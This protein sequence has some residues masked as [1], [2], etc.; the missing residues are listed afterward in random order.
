M[1]LQPL[2]SVRSVV[3][4]VC[5]SLLVLASL[6]FS[7]DGLEAGSPG[8]GGFYD[9]PDPLPAG[10]PGMVIRAEP[11]PVAPAGV[12]GWR[13]LYRSTRPDGSAR[14][15][16][17]VIFA[18]DE[19]AQAG[20][21]PVVAWAHPTTGIARR[22]APS[23]L[24]PLLPSRIAGLTDLLARGYVVTATDYP[25]LGTPSPHPYLI[26]ESEGRAVL[27]SVRAAAQLPEAGAGRTY[28]L[29]GHS[30]GGHAVLFA[31]QLAASYAPELRLVGIA[32]AAPPT[33]L[34]TLFALNV[35]SIVGRLL[36]AFAFVSWSEVY[37]DADYRHLVHAE[38]VPLIEAIA[39]TCVRT[40]PGLLAAVLPAWQLGPDFLRRQPQDVEP[41]RTLFAVNSPGA[42]PLGAPALIVQGTDDDIV[43]PWVTEAYVA[44]RCRGG[45]LVTLWLV[46]GLDHALAGQVSAPGVAAWLADRFAGLPVP[47]TCIVQQ[48]SLQTTARLEVAVLVHG[49]LPSRRRFGHSGKRAADTRVPERGHQ[50]G[51]ERPTALGDRCTID[52]AWAVH[53]H[54]GC[55]ALHLGTHDR[56][57][58]RLRHGVPPWQRH[59][60]TDVF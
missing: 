23:L 3:T 30:Q 17:G 7:V 15:V 6:V 60:P 24:A 18:P 53:A 19:P 56:I 34:A 20:G 52:R 10:P 46:P 50:E 26:G 39:R 29:W 12:R 5:A 32:A 36:A 51:A 21:R 41:W 58:G 55:E 11:F 33:D 16:S 44:A 59:F 47:D 8:D 40:T 9:P 31:G 35:E 54:R 28:A 49:G 42:V 38:A 43:W 13:V 48:A 2:H 14:A 4:A 57:A 27:D 45:E 1:T 37:P 25:G 22:C